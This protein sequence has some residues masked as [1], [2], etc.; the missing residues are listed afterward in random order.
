MTDHATKKCTEIGSIAC[1][2]RFRLNKLFPFCS[3]L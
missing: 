1:V 3:S 2:V